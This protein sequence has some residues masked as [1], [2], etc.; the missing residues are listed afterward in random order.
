MFFSKPEIGSD[1]SFKTWKKRN[2]KNDEEEEFNI[3]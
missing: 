3:S 1:P 2:G